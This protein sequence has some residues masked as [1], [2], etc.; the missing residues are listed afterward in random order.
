VIK[1][2]FSLIGGRK[3]TGGYNYLL[4]L[5]RTLDQQTPRKIEPV[6]FLGTDV[7]EDLVT[8]FRE[9]PRLI[10]VQ[11]EDFD[12]ATKSR[13]MMHAL[14]TGRDRLALQHFRQFAIQA[15]FESAQFY[16]WRF[17]IPAI[18]WAPD[19]QHRRLRKLFGVAAFWKREIGFRAQILSNRR[20]MVSSEDA[21]RDCERFYSVD[22]DAIHVVRFAVHPRLVDAQFAKSIA[23]QYGLPIRFFFLPNQFWTHKNHEC[24]L[25]AL[26][27]LKRRGES[28]VVAV[29]GNQQDRED[30]EHF[31][32]LSRMLEEWG[33]QHEFRILGLVPF[34]HVCALMH[35]CSALINPSFFEGWSTTVEEAKS[36]GTP[37][38]LSSIAV[39]KEQV[40]GRAI[41]FDP[42]AP[43]E[44]AEALSKFRGPSDTERLLALEQASQQAGARISRFADDFYA[45]LEKAV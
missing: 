33:L 18:A 37:M 6:L 20:I 8:P 9:F 23:D 40:E 11:H 43:E 24:V 1:V 28:V 12:E 22:S 32:R 45:L 41:F 39:H 3:W 2:A 30:P 13:R 15:V 10:V 14:V 25:R 31:P 29:T 35:R 44:L 7:P 36:M 38:I 19:F 5:L 34:A 21:K 42:T 4:N 16:G 27:I 26:H 17:P